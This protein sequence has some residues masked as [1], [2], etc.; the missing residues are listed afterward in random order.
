MNKEI[1]NNLRHIHK[2]LSSGKFIEAMED[3]LHDDVELR[4]ANDDSKIGKTHC[5]EF[6]RNF[7]DNDLAEFVR[8]EVGNYAIN[9]NKSFYD[10][11]MELKM[12]D[13]TTNEFTTGSGHRMEGWQDISRAVLPCIGVAPIPYRWIY[14]ASEFICYGILCSHLF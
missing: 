12:K 4:E 6:E 11:V 5:I 7:I 14:L 2:L 3:Y 13:G 10:A 1:E 9:G 8:Y